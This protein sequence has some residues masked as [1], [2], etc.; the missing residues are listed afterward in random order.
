VSVYRDGKYWR[1]R[2]R[3]NAGA[4]HTQIG[5]LTIDEAR[6]EAAT[7]DEA[8]RR[9]ALG[10]AP[11]AVERKPIESFLVEYAA[12]MDREGGGKHCATAL[13]A[14]AKAMDGIGARRVCDVT[15]DKIDKYLDA[16]G[17]RGRS[18]ET[19][20]HCRGY[21][22]AFF[23]WLETT[24]RIGKSPVRGLRPRSGLKTRRRQANTIEEVVAILTAAATGKP[25]E[26]T[27]CYLGYFAGMRQKEILELRWGDVD[28]REGLYRLIDARQKN[29]MDTITPLQPELVVYLCQVHAAV[30]AARG[31]PPEESDHIV[32]GAPTSARELSADRKALVARAGLQYRRLNG[33]VCDWHSMRH[34]FCTLFGRTGAPLQDL[35]AGMRHANADTTLG[36]S[37]LDIERVRNSLSKFPKMRPSEVTQSAQGQGV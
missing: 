20:N 26:L 16:L 12:H 27:A 3:D 4:R 32:I 15:V 19:L 21:V 34:T 37:H 6:H 8:I 14:I 1:L 18:A 29:R 9:G 31:T 22:R 23:S 36:Y 30:T 35:M 7:V 10:R 5:G 13:S 25:Y 24:D 28:L 17:A 11:T 33:E 2:W